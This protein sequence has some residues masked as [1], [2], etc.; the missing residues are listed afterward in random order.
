MSS[1]MLIGTTSCQKSFPPAVREMTPFG[2]GN[3]HHKFLRNASF[4]LTTRNPPTVR[5]GPIFVYLDC[6]LEFG[7]LEFP[8][9][10][11]GM[12]FFCSF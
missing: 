3:Q 9:D 10:L 5:V 1:D 8:L 4:Y 7:K 6:L 2:R 12:S 11:T